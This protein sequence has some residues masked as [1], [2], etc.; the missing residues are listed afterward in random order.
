MLSEK[1]F[2]EFFEV[3][4]NIFRRR[5]ISILG[6]SGSGLRFQEL[7]NSVN[8]E[9]A[10]QIDKELSKEAFNQHIRILKQTNLIEKIGT[11]HTDPFKLTNKGIYFFRLLN[12][13]RDKLG[14]KK[15]PYINFT[16]SLNFDISKDHINII[17]DLLIKRG[18]NSDYQDNAIKLLL[19]NDRKIPMELESEA[20]ICFRSYEDKYEIWLNIILKPVN[21]NLRDAIEELRKIRG[22]NFIKTF[23]KLS[24]L[25]ILYELRWAF[26]QLD[27]IESNDVELEIERFADRKIYLTDIEFKTR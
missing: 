12:E 15:S 17:P 13:L 10:D 11:K 23:I 8:I 7:M 24:A 19:N 3:T 16:Y 21:R 18:F 1:M 5:I 14:K 27:N 20:S 25:Q 4:N 26:Y 22:K 6:L 9:I 2:V